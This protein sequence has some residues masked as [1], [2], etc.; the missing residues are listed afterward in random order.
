MTVICWDGKTLAADKRQ[1][2]GGLHAT[3]MKLHKLPDGRLVAGCGTAP[4]IGEMLYWLAAGCDPSSFPALQRDAK[5]CASMLVV[6][7]GK[8]LQQYENT[9][10]PCVILNKQW[11]IGS[12]RDFALM[13]MHLGKT[14]AEAVELTSLFCTSCGNG[15]D[16]MTLEEPQ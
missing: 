5:E 2:H 3:T 13:A 6:T 1:S 11:S 9:P 7:R 8:P 15:M 16:T 4:M 14:A 10:Y 12:G